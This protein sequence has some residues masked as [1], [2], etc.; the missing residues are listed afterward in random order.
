ML[1]VVDVEVRFLRRQRT[2]SVCVPRGA[3]LLA[4]AREAGLPL[5]TACGGRA[6][7]ARC[8]VRVVA[9]EGSVSSES[10]RERRIKARNRIEPALRLACLTRLAGPV[11]VSAPYW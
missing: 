5:A 11:E 8:G 10:P 1:A 4:A 2:R 9:G 7:C 3:T 6:L